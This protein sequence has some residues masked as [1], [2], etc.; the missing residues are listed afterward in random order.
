MIE[1][2]MKSGPSI[3]RVSNLGLKFS[4]AF[5]FFF[6]SRLKKEFSLECIFSAFSE[7]IMASVLIDTSLLSSKIRCYD[8]FFQNGR[9]LCVVK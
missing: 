2:S 9:G 5:C 6:L 8:C 7:R 4:F 1:T 3:S